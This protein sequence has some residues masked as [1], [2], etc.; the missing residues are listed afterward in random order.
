MGE[1]YALL[2][3]SAGQG[4]PFGVSR[5]LTWLLALCSWVVCV[6]AHCR[7]RMTALVQTPHGES[8]R[9]LS[10]LGATRGVARS[11]WLGWLGPRG[12]SLR[13]VIASV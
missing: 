10:R 11:K 6:S 4:R 9:Y 8:L 1:E 2:C 5:R 7:P 3:Q 12:E 13:F